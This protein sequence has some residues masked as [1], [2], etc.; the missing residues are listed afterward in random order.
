MK[1]MKTE[2]RTGKKHLISI[3]IEELAK[4]TIPQI[5]VSKPLSQ[6]DAISHRHEEE[7]DIEG[8]DGAAQ[9][10]KQDFEVKLMETV[11]TD[12]RRASLREPI[13]IPQPLP[14]SDSEVSKLS[15]DSKN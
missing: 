4:P 13:E 5:V 14:K 11:H 1:K 15:S 3:Q 6:S 12:R 8:E 9:L 7:I 2:V 10:L